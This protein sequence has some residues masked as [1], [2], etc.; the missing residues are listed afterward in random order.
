MRC[1]HARRPRRCRPTVVCG[2]SLLGR[3]ALCFR[4][5][6]F[7]SLAQKK[8][9]LS[10]GI[11]FSAFFSASAA[12]LPSSDSLGNSSP[13]HHLK[14]FSSSWSACFTGGLSHSKPVSTRVFESLGFVA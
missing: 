9:A 10:F 14:V 4:L 5:F 7:F 3:Q 2:L 8:R 11:P 6:L 13:L 12:S 1:L